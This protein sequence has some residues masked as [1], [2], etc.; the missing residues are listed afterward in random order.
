MGATLKRA[1]VC[2]QANMI[3]FGDICRR[4]EDANLDPATRVSLSDYLDQRE[5]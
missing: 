2:D 1:W 5:G 3:G 4:N